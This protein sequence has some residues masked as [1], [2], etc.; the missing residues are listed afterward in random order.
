MKGTVPR[1]APL[2]ALL[3]ASMML[4]GAARAEDPPPEEPPV[5]W[6]NGDEEVE[7]GF[8]GTEGV[9]EDDWEAWEPG[10]PPPQA[11]MLRSLVIKVVLPPK[12]NLLRMSVRYA[13]FTPIDTTLTYRLAGGRGGVRPAA[14]QRHLDGQGTIRINQPL[15][16]GDALRARAA[17]DV[18]VQLSI[19][20]APGGCKPFFTRHL[21]IKSWR[22]PL[23]WRQVDTAFGGPT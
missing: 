11:C 8:E 2:L 6:W 18:F 10:K 20:A 21:T 19:P 3:L 22:G 1:L 23:I 15:S 14:K 16:V 12:R 5:E 4:A 17:T 9:A 7:E 13:T